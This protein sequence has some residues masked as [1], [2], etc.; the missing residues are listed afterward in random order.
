M[1]GSQPELCGMRTVGKMG[2]VGDW[3]LQPP[4]PR[5]LTADVGDKP[6]KPT[7]R[8]RYWVGFF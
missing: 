7:R 5:Q 6:H 2:Y 8:V 1:T 3:S 4:M